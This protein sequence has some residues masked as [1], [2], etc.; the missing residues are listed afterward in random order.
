MDYSRPELADRLAADYVVGT[1]RG[2]ARRRFESL[3]PAHPVLRSA[4]RS[5]QTRL[6][7]LTQALPPVTPPQRV[8]V[9]IDQH[10]FGAARRSA[11]VMP[12]AAHP[13]S[14]LTQAVHRWWE[15]LGL[16]QGLSAAASVAA[17]G[18]GVMLTLPEPIQPPIVVV[19][20]P[21]Q[22]ETRFVASV[23][24]D[25]RS[26]VLKPID[27]VTLTAS[28][29]YQLW[30]LPPSGAPRS[31]GLVSAKGGTTVQR[32]QLLKDTAAFAVSIEPPG[33]SPTGAPTGPVVS[34][35]KIDS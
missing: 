2:G 14:D 26:L 15:R 32:A 33:G 8:W 3:L 30:A 16:W 22:S 1:L 10:L 23:S 19:L 21:N 29:T 11:T 9:S 6:M 20:S 18:L 5:W 4:V 34:V 28:Q 31:L 35:G 25:G 7:P 12:G 24:A 27:G 13:A 17:I